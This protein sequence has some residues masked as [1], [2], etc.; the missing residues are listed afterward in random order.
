MVYILFL[1]LAFGMPWALPKLLPVNYWKL[2]I[3][4][5]FLAIVMLF[6]VAGGGAGAIQYQVIAMGLVV[7]TAV[8]CIRYAKQPSR[9]S[10]S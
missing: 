6:S 7:G 4:I 5:N 9:R 1:A 10:R 8:T 2:A 3:F